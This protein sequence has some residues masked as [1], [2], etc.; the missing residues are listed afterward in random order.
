MTKPQIERIYRCQSRVSSVTVG[1]QALINELPADSSVRD[2]LIAANENLAQGECE[3]LKA[4]ERSEEVMEF[5]HALEHFAE[6]T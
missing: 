6:A 5:V 2:R 3:L 1:L 4:M